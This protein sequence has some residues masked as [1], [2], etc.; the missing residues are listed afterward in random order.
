MHRSIRSH[1]LSRLFS[2]ALVVVSFAVADKQCISYAQTSSP[3]EQRERITAER[4]LQV[5]IR[6]PSQG[7]ALDRVFGYHIGAGDIGDVIAELSEKAA[8]ATDDNESGRHWMVV[9]LLQLQRSEDAAAIEALEKATQKLPNNTLAAYYHG[10]ALLL[11]GKTDKASAAMQRAIDL[12]PPKQDYLKIAGQ[13][14]RL[15]QRAGKPDDALRIWTTLEKSFPGDD[16]V[17]QRI[18]RA[19]LEEGDTQG[20]LIRFDALAKDARSPNDKIVFALRAADL[21]AQTGDKEQAIIDLESLL[22]KLRPGS[23]LHDEARR[24]I[25][26]AFLDSGDY[27]GLAEYYEAWIGDHPDDVGAVVRLARTL[28]IQGRGPEALS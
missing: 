1:R 15:Y 8:A 21:R 20:A 5:L 6:R 3:E 14:G 11:V 18:A 24:R 19:M 27:A 9:G 17:R 25:E 4:F 10:Q 28:S 7:T 26:S 13:L 12:K 22:A 23:Y 2:C 16:G